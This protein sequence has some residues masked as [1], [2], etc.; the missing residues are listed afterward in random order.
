MICKTHGTSW[1]WFAAFVQNP[2]P[3]KSWHWP[4]TLA[5]QIRCVTVN[6]KLRTAIAPS[7]TTY[8]HVCLPIQTCHDIAGCSN[9]LCRIGKA[10]ASTLGLF[11]LLV[12][13]CTIPDKCLQ[14]P[15]AGTD[16][17]Q[18]HELA[19]LPNVFPGSINGHKQAN[20]LRP[21]HYAVEGR[22]NFA[23]CPCQIKGMLL[24]HNS[25]CRY[26]PLLV[27]F[28]VCEHSLVLQHLFEGF[29]E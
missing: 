23:W 14:A 17:P 21:F 22:C 29:D 3:C 10:P 8:M 6:L 16:I 9:D 26:W 25:A 18:W 1:S 2:C 20:L 13:A 12:A 19:F 28:V 15:A 7:Y 5:K 4:T 27:M 24:S 11:G